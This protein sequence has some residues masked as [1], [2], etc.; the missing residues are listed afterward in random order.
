MKQSMGMEINFAVFS[1][2]KTKIYVKISVPNTTSFS[3][4]T[5]NRQ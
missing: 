3:T 5:I 2:L 1:K 4:R